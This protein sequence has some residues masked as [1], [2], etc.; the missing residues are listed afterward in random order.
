LDIVHRHL[1]KNK[2][3]RFALTGSSARKLRRGSSNLLAGRAFVYHLF[4]LTHLELAETFSLKEVLAWGTLPKVYSLKK[5]E[6]KS[7]FLEAYCHTYLKE[8]IRV[9][10][11]V[12]ALNPFR[13]FLEIAAQMNGQVLNFSKI[14]ED[15]GVD[16]KTVKSYYHILEDTLVGFFLP[17]FHRSLRKQ[18]ITSPK[19][20]LFDCGVKRALERN[21]DI[22]LREGTYEFGKAFEHFILTEIVRLNH[23]QRKN[24]RL[25]Y[26]LSKD[27]VE[28]DLIL[29]RPGKPLALVE[30]KSG[31]NVTPRQLSP[32]LRISKDIPGAE[33]IC[34]CREESPRKVGK[35]AVLPWMEG[36]E[37]LLGEKRP[38]GL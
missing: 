16:S 1:Q 27:G 5:Q 24:F 9:E 22:P 14:A 18:Q 19:F 30:I 32:L 13:L 38:G 10:Q 12:R 7:L 4:P 23:Y 29:D 20:Y 26:F 11:L 21:L 33:A 8:E 25:S 31:K 6:E 36:L 15:I 17:A 28:I 37:R 2:N 3:V 35:V 34:L